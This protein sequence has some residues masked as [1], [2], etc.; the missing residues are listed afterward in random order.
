LLYSQLRLDVLAISEERRLTVADINERQQLRY[1]FLSLS[2]NFI[3]TNGDE[4]VCEVDFEKC[5]IWTKVVDVTT[6]GMCSCF[7]TLLHPQNHA[8]VE[9]DS[10]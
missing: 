4:S 5:L 3:T 7:S 10:Q 9:P 8:A 1:V 2:E 6:G